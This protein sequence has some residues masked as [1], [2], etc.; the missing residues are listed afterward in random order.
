MIARIRANRKSQTTWL[1]TWPI[2]PAVLVRSS[3]TGLRSPEIPHEANRRAFKPVI[4]AKRM[5]TAFPSVGVLRG[6]RIASRSE[7]AA[8]AASRKFVLE[9]ATFAVFVKTRWQKMAVPAAAV[10]PSR[11]SA[12]SSHIN[13]LHDLQPRAHPSLRRRL[14]TSWASLPSSD[15]NS[16]A[17]S[18]SDRLGSSSL[19]RK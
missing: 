7:E 8:A 1:V 5:E 17:L 13:R 16:A 10:Y 4:T 19:T 18:G 6:D 9:A 14:Q 15:Q 11:G 12:G 2:M 3:P